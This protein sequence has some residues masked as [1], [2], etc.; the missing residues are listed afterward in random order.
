MPTPTD[1]PSPSGLSLTAR[2]SRAATATRCRMSH[3]P[4]AAALE[5]QSTPTTTRCEVTTLHDA[6]LGGQ[7]NAA[8]EVPRLTHVRPTLMTIQ[9]RPQ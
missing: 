9:R 1:T 7:V 6:A 3:F 2:F 8:R 4:V 5:S